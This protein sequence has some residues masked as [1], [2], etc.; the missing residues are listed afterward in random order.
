MLAGRFWEV[1]EGVLAWCGEGGEGGLD[2]QVTCEESQSEE[3]D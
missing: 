2:V 3:V 1:E